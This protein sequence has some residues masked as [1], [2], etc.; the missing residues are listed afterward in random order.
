MHPGYGFLSENADFA[1]AVEDAG[2][3]WIGPPPEAMEAM[4]RKISSRERMKAAGVPVVPGALI[5]TPEENEEKISLNGEEGAAR[6]GA[7]PRAAGR[8]AASGTLEEIPSSLS[9]SSLKEIHSLGLPVVVK[10]SAGGGGKGMR[11]VREP[12]ELPDAIASCRREAAAAFG[13]GTV[14]VEKYLERPRH[15]EVQVFGDWHGDVVA[16]GERECSL[17]RRHQKVSRSARLRR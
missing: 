7:A 14:Y 8:P 5:G 13:D 12:S 1:R 2:M 16:I 10:A 17:Q 11:I 3:V 6:G 4:G 15:V 9:P